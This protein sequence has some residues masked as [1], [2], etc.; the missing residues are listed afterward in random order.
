M[1]GVWAGLRYRNPSPQIRVFPDE[2]SLNVARSGERKLRNH[3]ALFLASSWSIVFLL[4]G[5]Q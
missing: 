3:Y 4:E 2:G 1:R 5:I